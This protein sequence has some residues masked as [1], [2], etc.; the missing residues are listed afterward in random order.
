MSQLIFSWIHRLLG[1]LIGSS[2]ALRDAYELR[3]SHQNDYSLPRDLLA[4]VMNDATVTS[5]SLMTSFY[6][7][8]K[9]PVT[10]FGSCQLPHAL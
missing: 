6:E 10:Y 2:L 4:R 8:R 9:R 7:E 3:T 1:Q 5:E